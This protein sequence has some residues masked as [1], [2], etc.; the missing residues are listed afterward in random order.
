MNYS[1]IS[2][3]LVEDNPGDARLIGEMLKE[4][5]YSSARFHS[6]RT[7]KEARDAPMPHASVATVLLDLSLPDSDGI[8]TL[9]GIRKGYADSAIIILTGLDDEEMAL[10][11]LREGA[12]SYV[13][14]NEMSASL[15]G[16]TLRYSIERHGFIKRIRQEEYRTAE[17]HA[18]ERSMR[19]ALKKE[20]ELHALKS[21]FVSLVSHEFRSPLAV[22]QGSIDLIERYAAGPDVEKVHGHTS[23]IRTK[24]HELTS[25][26]TDVLSLAKLEQGEMPCVPIE[27]DLGEVC[28]EVMD[29]M[30]SVLRPGQQ[31]THEHVGDDRTMMHDKQMFARVLNN[32]LSNAIKYSHGNKPIRIHTSIAM[33]RVEVS[34]HDEGIGIPQEEQQLL[35]ERF[36]RGSNVDA[37]PGTGL[38]LS[39]IKQYL[40][41]MGGRIRFTSVPG[42]TVFTVEL[43]QHMSI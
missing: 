23:K 15:L 28:N 8:D 30:R 19:A 5:E 17:L 3:L 27:F 43:P 11:A 14:K 9:I 1:D 42:K 21:R 26:L 18:N 22:I 2:I 20:K 34:V 33:G 10:R 12:Q 25:I 31:M 36:Y 40:D 35:F 7:M 41:I 39:I 32:L 37:I 13:T 6:A 38:G 29:D 24:I 4:T 16:R